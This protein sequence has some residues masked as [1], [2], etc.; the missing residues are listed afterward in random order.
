MIEKKLQLLLLYLL[1]S[2]LS[3]GQSY[4]IKGLEL[5]NSHAVNPAYIISDSKFQ[6]NILPYNNSGF[7]DR[8][9]LSSFIMSIPKYNSGVG[10]DFS[11]GDM[12]PLNQVSLNFNYAY[13]HSFTE[14]L[15][16]TGGIRI[17]Y[18]RLKFEHA[19]FTDFKVISRYGYNTTI[20]AS[21]KYKKLHSGL[22]AAI[23]LI[24]RREIYIYE[25]GTETSK[26]QNPDTNYNFLLGYSLG[27]K[28]K[29]LFD[30]LLS[31]QHSQDFTTW[32][33]GA[34]TLIKNFVGIGFTAG[35]ITSFS[36]SLNFKN[37]VSFILGIYTRVDRFK[38][39]ID[40]S[41]MNING[42]IRITL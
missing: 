31:I 41:Q 8:G 24:N 22:S 28:N 27:K 36:T 3:F 15:S 4:S 33:L 12:S 17:N 39:T 9:F 20:G 5:Y 35:D 30:P 38:Y 18:S 26:E 11:K 6:F 40:V 21:F 1:L 16:L 23:P 34:N 42:Q 19:N 29:F 10:I 2:N 37:K 32:Y 13:K 14:D 25:T 7:H